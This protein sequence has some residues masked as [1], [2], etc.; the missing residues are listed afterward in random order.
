MDFLKSG[1]FTLGCNYWA[2]HAGTNMWN[3]WDEKIVDQDLKRLKD[4]GVEALR[5]F[6]LWSDF[7]P[8][9]WLYGAGGRKVEIANGERFLDAENPDDMAGLD[10]TCMSHFH[11]LCQLASRYELK[12]IVALITGWMS[13]RLYVPRMLEGV[14]V[15]TDPLAVQYEI[16]FIERFIGRFRKEACIA[17]WEFGNE[18]NCMGESTREQNWLWSKALASAIRLSDPTR[19]VYSGMH[20]LGLDKQWRVE[21]QG[22]ICDMLTVHPYSVFT[23]YCHAAPLPAMRTVMHGA[24]E[25]TMYHDLGRKPCFVE[26]TGSLGSIMANDQLV[27]DFAFT[28]MFS[29][30]AQD[31]R[32][33]FWWCANDQ[34]QLSH[35]PYDWCDVEKELGLLREDGS[36]KPVG[37]AL[38]RFKTFKDQLP[39]SSLPPRKVDAVCLLNPEADPWGMAY[40]SFLL[41]KQASLNISFA[42]V[43]DCLPDSSIYL[44]PS[45]P[46]GVNMLRNRLYHPLMEKVKA[47]A[48]LYISYDGAT[49]SP[50]EQITGCRSGGKY[51]TEEHRIRL[52]EE[53]FEIQR[54]YVV[55]LLPEKAQPIAFD[56]SGKPALT[57][58]DLGRGSIL[59]LNAPLERFLLSGPDRFAE[60]KPDYYRFYS[61][62]KEV[63]KV[64]ETVT[65]HHKML[66][67]TEH[68]MGDGV[69]TVIA[70]NHSAKIV[71]ESFTFHGV[72]LKDSLYGQV[73]A[74]G[75]CSIPPYD[76]VCFRVKNDPSDFAQ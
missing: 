7:Q 25:L 18:C 40:A 36:V 76:A 16:K 46:L 4:T 20:S 70:V 65:K 13:G 11:S 71:K 5:V 23:P 2:S 21:D 49:F 1:T 42:S 51:L 31:G 24:A 38:K 17:A 54:Q 45:V 57:R 73:G 27:G 3:Q 43:E 74:D 56:G 66:A 39:F 48:V 12:L 58:Y 60:E 33:Y 19:P 64:K 41:G 63:A 61:Y 34:L 28:S 15:I 8:L 26:E 30:Y 35:A 53:E 22:E 72:V 52:F 67:V 50:F 29:A 32:G 68:A 37:Q 9:N 6:P 14:N 44:L 62:I 75:S 59:F 69:T 10:E 47:G 55:D